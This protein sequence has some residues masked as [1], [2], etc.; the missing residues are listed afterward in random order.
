[1]MD[2]RDIIFAL[3][4]GTRVVVGIVGI[5]NNGKFQVLAV[6]Q[7]EHESRA[8]FDGQ[9]HDIDKVANVV[10]KIK[11]RLEDSLNIKLTEVCIAAAGRSLK[12]Q[13]ARAEK[14]IDEEHEITVED[15]DNLELEALEIAQNSIVSQSGVT[16]YHTVGYTV[17]NY[18]LN[19]FPITNLKGHKGRE[20]AVEIL[21]TFLPYDVVEGLYAAVK[22][23]GLEV[24]YI[25]LEPIAAINVAI[26]PEIR[27]L[28]IAL[29]DIG[30]GTSDIAISK[31][32][33]IIAYSMVP[34]AGDEITESIATY[35][36]TDFNT[37]E[38]IK[39][40][41]KKEIKFKDVLNIE[42]KITKEEVMEIIAP[43]VKVL[44]QKICNEIIKYNGKSPSA[45]FLVGG[46]SNLPNLPEEIASILNLPINRVSV[47]DIKSVEIL[48]YKGKTLKGPESITPIG[49]AYSA[50]INRRKDFIKVS[51]DNETIKIFNIKNP[52]VMDV[53]VAINYDSKNLIVQNGKDLVFN[54]NGQ[55]IVVKGEEGTPPKI[56]VNDSLANLK[57]PI[58]DGDEITIIKGQKGQDATITAGE[59]LKQQKGKIIFVNDSKV[60]QNYVI[61]NGDEIVIKEDLTSFVVTVNGKEVVLK[62]KEEYLFVDVFN[63]IDLKLDNN[64]VP[65]MKLNGRRASYTDILKP[66]DNIEIEI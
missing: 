4:I 26:P 8:M 21:A 14:N 56:Y 9:V 65:E 44:A 40:S 64:K 28:N 13:S 45:V 23:A 63:F 32:G 36:L 49:I 29:V 42:H 19:S 61:K 1:M 57:T 52:T 5:E 39:K 17:S 6:E 47:R 34:Y 11:R 51:I 24:S 2:N 53:L 10:E 58:K 62:G 38:K 12:T 54:L 50:M 15:I 22:K 55:K 7:M 48:D 3:D 43:Q 18:Y 66:G 20:I 27:M 25:T 16:K 35:F 41:T 59:L 33:N 46:S 31:E 37:A 30:A 60:D